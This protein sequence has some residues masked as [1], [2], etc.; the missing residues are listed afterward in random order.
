M[1]LNNILRGSSIFQIIPSELLY[2]QCSFN[3]VCLQKLVKVV[4]TILRYKKKD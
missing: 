2:K 4:F 1:K 3:F